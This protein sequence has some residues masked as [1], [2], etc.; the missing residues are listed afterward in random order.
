MN[1]NI[2]NSCAVAC[3]SKNIL[4]LCQ[5]PTYKHADTAVHHENIPLEHRNR[6]NSSK[7]EKP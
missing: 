7:I 1:K 6:S 2:M 3:E 4:T 5:N